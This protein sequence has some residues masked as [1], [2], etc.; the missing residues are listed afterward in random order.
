MTWCHLRQQVIT[1]AN[2]G[3]DLCHHMKS[4]GRNELKATLKSVKYRKHFKF[5]SQYMLSYR[6]YQCIMYN[7]PICFSYIIYLPCLSV[8]QKNLFSKLRSL[9]GMTGKVSK[10]LVSTY[11]LACLTEMGLY[12]KK[13][14][15]HESGCNFK[16]TFILRISWNLLGWWYIYASGN[17]VT[18]SP[19]THVLT[20]IPAWVS[21]HI[22]YKVWDEITYYGYVI[23]SHALLGMWLL[24][25]A[26]IKVKT[27]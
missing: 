26:G 3:S 18:S 23:S 27:C 15:Q 19:I 1:W 4:L 12:K 11:R 22:H 8:D 25:H 14:P 21:N 7:D 13:C 6:I 17:L 10:L 20:L 9:I 16:C 24:I 5:E 2:I